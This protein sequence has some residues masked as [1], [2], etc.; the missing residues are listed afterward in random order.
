MWCKYD[1]LHDSGGQDTI[2]SRETFFREKLSFNGIAHLNSKLPLIT[3]NEY[4]IEFESVLISSNAE[5]RYKF[6]ITDIRQ[7]KL[8]ILIKQRRRKINSVV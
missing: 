4:V 8:A 3:G 6:F 7:M 2:I 5:K 1:F